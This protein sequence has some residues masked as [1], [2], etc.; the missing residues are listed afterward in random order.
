M[1]SGVGKS[2]SPAPKLITRSPAARIARALAVTAS[3]AEGAMAPT[4]REIR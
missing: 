3:V 4:R 1:C 2:G